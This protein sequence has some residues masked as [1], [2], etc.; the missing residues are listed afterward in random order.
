MLHVTVSGVVLLFLLCYA[1]NCSHY[2]LNSPFPLGL[3]RSGWEGSFEAVLSN[4]PS[5]AKSV[6]PLYISQ[7]PQQVA[8]V[9]GNTLNEL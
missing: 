8:D 5:G 1:Q 7:S 9:E 6:H 3:E 2:C 4:P